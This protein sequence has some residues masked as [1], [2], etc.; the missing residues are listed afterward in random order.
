MEPRDLRSLPS[1]HDGEVV[2]LLGAR[3]RGVEYL[4]AARHRAGED[5]KQAHVADVGLAM[6]LEDEGGEWGVVL[7][8][9]LDRVIALGP[10]ECVDLLHLVRIRHQLH[11]RGEHGARA[12]VVR[13][14][15]AEEGEQLHP[16]HR[17]LHGADRLVA[18]DLAAVEVA[19]EE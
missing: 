14:R 1:L 7:R 3:P 15:D 6:R 16:L 9:D 8:M 17:V 11:D 5:A 18:S 12:V 10:D 4:V 13:G 19:L 2:Q